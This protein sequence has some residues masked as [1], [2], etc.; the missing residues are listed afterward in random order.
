MF[1]IVGL[2]NPGKRFDLTRH[3]AGFL[4]LDLLAERLGTKINKIKFQ[5][6]IGEAQ[7]GGEKLVLMKP[8]TFMNLSGEAVR[9][10]AEYYKIPSEHI[11]VIYDDI[12]IAFG[13]LRLRPKG[14]AGTHNGMRNIL[15]QLETEHFPRVRIGIKGDRRGAELH[16]YVL[17]R[18]AKEDERTLKEVLKCA[19]DAALAIVEEGVDSA[20]N[21]FNHAPSSDDKRSE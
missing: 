17:S 14:S 2:G 19:A 5:S 6:L 12:D 4:A 21:R 16:E 7:F 10:A 11:I 18:F 13:S 20:M 15:Y 1:L 3:N 8:Q 9:A